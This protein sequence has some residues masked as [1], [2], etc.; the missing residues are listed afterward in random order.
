MLCHARFFFCSTP[1]WLDK[2]T[3][4][5]VNQGTVNQ[6]NSKNKKN[7]Q[8]A[9]QPNKWRLKI[10]ANTH[11]HT[12]IAKYIRKI[13]TSKCEWVA[14]KNQLVR[15]HA[16]SLRLNNTP[17]FFTSM[18]FGVGWM[19]ANKSAAAKNPAGQIISIFLRLFPALALFFFA[20]NFLC[21][22]FFFG[23]T[24]ARGCRIRRKERM[25]GSFLAVHVIVV[26]VMRNGARQ[27]K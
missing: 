5:A 17:G 4:N 6:T 9:N 20:C 22:I 11:T 8:L 10:H 19:N 27:L 2:A 1:K 7:S 12:S 3:N 18:W 21:G 23:K 15:P 26:V 14:L 13:N 24:V 16:P 25:G